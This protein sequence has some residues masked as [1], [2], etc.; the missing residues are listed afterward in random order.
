MF[1]QRKYGFTFTQKI[2]LAAILLL[3]LL[4]SCEKEKEVE[5]SAISNACLQDF[6]SYPRQVLLHEQFFDN[7]NN[8][9]ELDPNHLVT[10]TIV[11]N[12]SNYIHIDHGLYIVISGLLDNLSQ[13][14]KLSATNTLSD[15]P[16]VD[17]LGVEIKIE[18]LGHK[19]RMAILYEAFHS[20]D[21]QWT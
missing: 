4:W 11:N 14:Q 5:T 9:V 7:R 3:N 20:H 13:D 21:L 17:Y 8:W 19:D 6:D 1:W 2:V 16:D 10:D 12:D 18:T 15:L